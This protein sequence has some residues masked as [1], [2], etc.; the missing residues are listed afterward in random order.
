MAIDANT[1]R[2]I[3][4]LARIELPEAEVPG[5]GTEVNAILRFVEQLGEVDVSG[6]PPMTSVTPQRQN[7]R[8]DRVEAGGDPRAILANAPDHDSDYFRVPRV[9][10]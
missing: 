5:I 3:A 4:K 6:I 10:E 8:P 7:L 9:V 2:R 1:I